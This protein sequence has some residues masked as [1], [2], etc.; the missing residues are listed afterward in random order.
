MTPGLTEFAI[1]IGAHL[2]TDAAKNAVKRAFELVKTRRPDLDAAIKS[3][4][5][6]ADMER[7]YRSALGVIRAEADHGMIDIDTALFTALAAVK[8]DHQHGRI[9]LHNVSVESPRFE[10]GGVGGSTGATVLQGHND[11]RTPHTGVTVTGH[12]QLSGGASIVSGK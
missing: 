10:V 2:T 6:A 5:N 9:Y 7:V 11:F 12:V 3:A 4:S 8:F 1:A